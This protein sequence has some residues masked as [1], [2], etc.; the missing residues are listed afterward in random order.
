MLEAVGDAARDEARGR[1]PDQ[2]LARRAGRARPAPTAAPA[3]RRARRSPPG[4]RARPRPRR[5]RAR[6]APAPRAGRA[7]RRAAR[8]GVVGSV[9]ER[10][11]PRAPR[12]R[13]PRRRAGCRP[14]ALREP[15]PHRRRRLEAARAARRRRPAPSGSSRTVTGQSGRVSSSSGRARQS[16]SSGAS[17]TS[18]GSAREQ[19][20]QR[21]LGPVDVVDQHDERPL[22]PRPPARNAAIASASLV[23]GRRALGEPEQLRDPRRH[24]RARASSAESLVPD[25]GQLAHDLRDGP[26]G[27]PLAVGEAGAAHDTRA[28]RRSGRRAPPPAATCPTPGSPT[29]VT[30]RQR[31]RERPRRTRA[32]AAPAPPRG[33]R[34]AS[35]AAAR[36]GRH[37]PRAAG[38]RASGSD[39][40]FASAARPA[41]RVTASRT[42]RYVVSPSSTSPGPAACSSRA[43]TFTASP[44]TN[45]S[46]G[47]R[48]PRR[49]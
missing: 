13:A 19:V 39:F 17:P 22:R 25:P 42:S 11:R 9:V 6:R 43:A 20:E 33:R 40:P 41:R 31:R 30:S 21:R 18:A 48:R 26:E 38:T 12:P 23:G 35:P 3:R 4:G 2:V 46:L 47:S 36:P 15:H 8:S 45:V 10:R 37:R 1:E 16:T 44:V 24:A 49:C 34:A 7:G 28:R 29:T 32:R 27:D 14:A 5:A